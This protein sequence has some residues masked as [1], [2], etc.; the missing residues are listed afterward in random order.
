MNIS[1]SKKSEGINQSA[2]HKESK[3]EFR[4]QMSSKANLA[5]IISMDDDPEEIFEILDLLGTLQ[6]RY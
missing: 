4:K 3:G 6:D 1:C 5:D 2:L